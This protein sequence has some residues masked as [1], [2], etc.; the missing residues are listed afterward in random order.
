MAATTI[1]AGGVSVA[2]H[3]IAPGEVVT[4]VI[5]GDSFKIGRDQTIRLLSLNA[6]ET[7]YCY[8][9]KSKEYLAKKIEGKRVI[10]KDMQTDRYGRI[11]ALVYIKG[12]LV[13]EY[14]V[15]NGLALHLWDNTNVKESLGAANDYARENRLGIFSPE[16]YQIDA[17]NKKCPIKGSINVDTKEKTYT[18]PNCDRYSLTVIE[19]YK[20]EDWFCTEEAAKNAGFVK[21]KNCN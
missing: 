6:P 19:K 11:M 17:P 2:K 16:C 18:M 9:D 15:K 13:N 12:E 8:G 4:Q 1:I 20:G 7:K 14:M 3:T 10:L 5:D 21:S